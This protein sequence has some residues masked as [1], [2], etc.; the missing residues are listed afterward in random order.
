[1]SNGVLGIAVNLLS[2]PVSVT[3]RTSVIQGY[4][5]YSVARREEAAA[6]YKAVRLV[7]SSLG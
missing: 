4:L 3:L 2:P 1:M 5:V 6:S 7:K